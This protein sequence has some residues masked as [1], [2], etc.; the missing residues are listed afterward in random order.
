MRPTDWAPLADSDPIPGDPSTIRELANHLLGI[1]EAIRNET[2]RMSEIDSGEIWDSD[3][4]V[5]FAEMQE[6]L[7]PDLELAATRYE[8]VANALFTYEG[9]LSS[10]QSEAD[11]ALVRAQEA[12][13]DLDTATNGIG[14]ME[15]WADE[16]QRLADE[17][18]QAAEPGTPPV[19]AEPWTGTDYYALQADAEER[20]SQ[21]RTDLE[22]A[23]EARD[24]AA[25]T[26]EEAIEGASNDDLENPGAF[27]SFLLAA[28]DVLSIAGAVLGV[29][30]IFFPVLA[31]LALIV[32]G[33]SLLLNAGLAAAGSK[34]WNDAMWDA[35]G[36]VTF[37]AG[38]A[39]NLGSRIV[40]SR[41]ALQAMNRASSRAFSATM[42]RVSASQSR[43]ALLSRT[44]LRGLSTTN[45][46]G[47]TIYGAAARSR[48]LSQYDNTIATA[49]RQRTA[50]HHSRDLLRNRYNSIRY[51]QPVPW[52]GWR[53]THRYAGQNFMNTVVPASPRMDGGLGLTG[54]VFD[55]GGT[56]VVGG[57][58]VDG[59]VNN[60]ATAE[61][62]GHAPQPR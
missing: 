40:R 1:A 28:A 41:G 54:V 37:G 21:A 43:S 47:R 29:L 61:H 3:A 36:L 51:E 33:V 19:E 31:P 48:L 58:Q 45:A 34:D 25:S 17:A 15:E 4:A 9:S 42:T 8:S 24:E 53:N 62:W 39:F 11:A 50:A 22:G 57:I 46:Q 32:G 5:T 56:T 26:A 52:T 12:Q 23:V 6:A 59:A 35:I 38:R 55:L 60:M 7:P 27:E 2:T 16:S 10:A 44:S 49:T 13:A 14:Q 20:I 30:S 18:N